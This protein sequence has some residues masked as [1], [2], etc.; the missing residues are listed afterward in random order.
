MKFYTGSG[1]IQVRRYRKMFF[2]VCINGPF[3]SKH[4][5]MAESTLQSIPMTDI[6]GSRQ[7]SMGTLSEKL[8]QLVLKEAQFGYR[9]WSYVQRGFAKF[10]PVSSY[11]RSNQKKNQ[12][13]TFFKDEKSRVRGWLLKISSWFWAKIWFLF[14]I[15]SPRTIHR[16]NSPLRPWWK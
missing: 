3:P 6:L 8:N 1:G 7:L 5:A 16:Q 4:F 14:R 10:W 11:W 12:T 9:R 13:N 2:F 15:I